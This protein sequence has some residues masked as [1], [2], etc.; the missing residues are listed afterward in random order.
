MSNLIGRTQELQIIRAC[1]HLA[2]HLVLEGPVGVGKTFL[3]QHAA[4]LTDRPLIRIDGDPQFSS[5]KLLGYFDPPMVIEHGY[6]PDFFIEGPLLQAMNEGAV[7][8]INELNRLPT[9]A[10]NLLLTALDEKK[11]FV[12][13]LGWKQAQAGFCVIATQNP[14]EFIGT[15]RLSEALLDRF[16]RLCIDY[17]SYEEEMAMVEPISVPA[18]IKEKA[19]QLI[20]E[21]RHH[22]QIRRG[23]SI[24]AAQSLLL[25]YQ[26]L[27]DFDLCA[28]L[29]LSTRIE[30]KEE[31][32]FS[33]QTL[34]AELEKKKYN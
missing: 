19:V 32:P 14:Q 23:A 17:Q 2:K 27:Q 28:Q 5:E 7:L 30:W 11:L 16:E 15:Q 12:P 6:Q 34:I 1:I 31:N 26:E 22:P 10:Q 4:S 3:A 20:R 13:R 18:Q 9:M 24:R 25:L 33:L 29:S 21:T 8:F